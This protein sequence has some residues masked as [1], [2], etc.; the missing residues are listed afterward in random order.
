MRA[1]FSFVSVLV[2]IIA[3][4]PSRA[5]ELQVPRDFASIQS[6][7][8]AAQDSGQTTLEHA[9]TLARMLVSGADATIGIFEAKYHY[10]YWRPVTGIRAGDADGNPDTVG[11]AGWTPFLVTPPHPSYIS[12]HSA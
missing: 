3:G 2:V 6:A 7:I 9:S 4:R 1:A 5:A 10:D 11:D 8:D 12:G